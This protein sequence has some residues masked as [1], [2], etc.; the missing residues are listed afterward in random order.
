[1][2]LEGAVLISL[3]QEYL[4]GL[5][6]PTIS[7]LEVQKLA[8]FM[9]EA[10]EPLKLRY[11]KRVDDLYADNL[12][13]VLLRM[14]GRFIE[15]AQEAE[16]HLAKPLNLKPNSIGIARALLKDYP[17]TVA[18]FERVVHLMEAFESAYGTEL[19]VTAHWAM[20]H[21]K[22]KDDDQLIAHIHQWNK[23]KL[24]PQH[25]LLAKETLVAQGRVN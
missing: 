22:I 17:E 13:D 14:E 3:M 23:Q 20:C 11:R 21:E 1:M 16:D 9:Q 6:D 2:T 24:K 15:G 12:L 18:R 4:N 7:L 10:G 25:I 19:L 8:Y 5:I